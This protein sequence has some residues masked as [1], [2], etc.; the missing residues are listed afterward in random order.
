MTSAP[1]GEGDAAA[2][3]TFARRWLRVELA[4]V[5]SKSFVRPGTAMLVASTAV[6]TALLSRTIQLWVSSSLAAHGLAFLA[7][8]ALAVALYSLTASWVE[9]RSFAAAPHRWLLPV[10]GGWAGAY[11]RPDRRGRMTL[12]SVWASPRGQHLGSHLI[13]H[14]CAEMDARGCDLH[15]VAVNH[16]VARFYRRFGF[17]PVRQGRFAYRMLRPASDAAAAVRPG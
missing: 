7:G 11:A 9:A 13:Q 3:R 5:L 10:S 14:I 17:E 1:E 8:A 4:S 16:R 6:L 2:A 12:Y 15:L